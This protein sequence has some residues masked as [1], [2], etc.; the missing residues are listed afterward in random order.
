MSERFPPLAEVARDL[1]NGRQTARAL[2]ETASEN[3]AASEARLGAYKTWDGERAAALAGH[4]DALFARGIDLGPLMGVPV[5]VKDLYGV[6]GLPTFAGTDAALPEAWERPGPVVRRPLAQLAPIMGKT[7]TVEF[8]FGGIGL[9][10]H[11]DAPV[12][13]WSGADGR[14][15]P[16]GSS[17][18][19]GVSLAQGSALVALGTDTAG[20]VRIP[21]AV[22]GQVGLK[23]T[24]GRWPL[25]GI[26]P[27]SPSFDTPGLLCRSVRDV[28]FAFAALD[29]GET[30]ATTPAAIGGLRIGLVGGPL[31]EGMD[32]SVGAVLERA[33]AATEGA[34]AVLRAVTVPGADDVLALFRQG[35]LAAPELAAFLAAEFPERVARL[36]PIVRARVEA[37]E[38][39]TATEYLRRKMAL[40]GHGRASLAA[41]ETCDVVASVTVPITPPL[42]DA[43]AMPEAYATANMM[44]LRNTALAN[45]MGWCALSL[46]IGL[47][48]AGMPV[49]LQLMAPPW[50]ETRLLAAAL[51]VEGVLGAGEQGLGRPPIWD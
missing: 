41:F 11:W 29:P 28:A 40:A 32:A 5:S 48:A 42:V 25:E 16:G 3:H 50:A 18:G 12:N 21:A 38:G 30:D 26:V 10:A 47:D 44:V 22:T 4:A 19:A 1:R 31:E 46:P 39:M 36:D 35:G 20:S 9:N 24:H 14:R 2:V 23:L 17:S 13:P 27:L 49:G 51:A 15:I 6:P 33:L 45:M 8:A 43:V 37:A 34:G 7:H